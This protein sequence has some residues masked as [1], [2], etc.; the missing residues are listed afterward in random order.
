[1][2]K[3][4]TIYI[5]GL[6]V[7]LLAACDNDLDQT[8]PLD[9]ETS[10]LT[11]FSGVLNAAY[12]YQTGVVTPQAMM[13]E[14]RSDNVAADEDPYLSWKTFNSDLAGLDMKGPVFGPFY[15]NLYKS[16]LSANNVITNSSDATEIA[17]AKFLRGLSYFKLVMVF[18]DVSVILTPQLTVLE[19]PEFDL[20][21]V[22]ANSVYDDVIIP[23]LEDAI[24]DLDNSGISSGRASQIAAQAVLGKVYL[25]RGNYV[26]AAV[27]FA[28]VISAAASAGVSLEG[29][30]ANV[31][32]DESTEILFATQLSSSISIASGSSS[33]TTF[34][35]WFH[36]DDTKANDSPVT[37]SLV[38]AFDASTAAA[39]ATDL[40][41]ALSVDDVK[42]IGIKYTGGLDQ[43]FIEIRLTDV[44]L[45]YAEALNESGAAATTVL[46]LLDPIRT[47]AGLNSLTGTISSQSDVRTAIANER[48]VELAF[49]GHRWFDLVRTGTVDAAIGQ[50]ISSDYY[51][52]P[53]PSTEI[54]ASAGVITQNPGY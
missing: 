18:G 47:R 54:T 11:D 39:G 40:R 32:T 19:I 6:S 22:S 46:P 27:E 31:V 23:D 51:I 41:K 17:E 34:V 25:Y 28:E 48:R 38:A 21:R 24:S 36:G 5:I 44:I 30:F 8:P 15:T 29:D 2:K 53:I 49:E 7:L 10:T 16:I 12:Y 37:T 50:V 9:I 20:T 4:K 14:F 42:R 1:M 13:G 43:D 45:M 33:S 35:G 3:I 52:F 26:N